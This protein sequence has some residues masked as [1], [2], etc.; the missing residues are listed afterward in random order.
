MTQAILYILTG[1]TLFAGGRQLLRVNSLS[2]QALPLGLMYL[3]LA[4]FALV[5]AVGHTPLALSSLL[6]L[7]KLTVSLGLLL[8]LAVLW[9]IALR[10]GCRPLLLLDLLTALWLL[11]LLQNLTAPASLLYTDPAASVTGLQPGINPWWTA[12]ELSML[13]TVAFG[14]WA[15]WQLYRR[16]E[17]ITA[18]SCA[19]GLGL[20]ALAGLFDHL[21]TAHWI[22]GVFLTPFGFLGYLTSCSLQ[23][24][25]Q[26]WYQQRHPAAP[27]VIYS[28]SYVPDHASF[29]SDV[30]QLRTPALRTRVKQQ[31]ETGNSQR[32]E[33][34]TQA[35]QPTPE[36][37]PAGYTSHMQ[38]DSAATE[39]P[40][41]PAA[42]KPA[43]SAIDQNLLHA[44]TDNLIDIAVYATMALNRCKHG[45][46]DPLVLEALCR[47]I[48]VRAIKTRRI[49]SQLSEDKQ[50]G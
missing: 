19:A 17:R 50:S 44:V 22:H 2:S 25:L 30:S 38:A 49:A 18:L 48:R 46:T 21:V 12:V 24:A 37:Q 20:L 16:G 23:P 41:G 45:D 36:P 27:L 5:S 8:W 42:S 32:P 28:L 6:P 35:G 43:G 13:A 14:V 26:R 7:G 31:R 39:T 9:H 4:G 1:L 47:K 29:H 33:V 34:E 15:C 3:L 40:P 11:F 10:T